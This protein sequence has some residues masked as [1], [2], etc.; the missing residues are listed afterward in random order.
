M[1]QVN[2]PGSPLVAAIVAS[3]AQVISSVERFIDVSL[4]ESDEY[5]VLAHGYQFIVHPQVLS[6]KYS[7]SAAFIASRW[8]IQPGMTVLDVGTGSGILAVLAAAAGA[9]HVTAVDVNQHAVRI[10]ERNA[11]LNGFENEISVGW[12][13]VFHSIEE[14]QQFDRIVVNAPYWNRCADP[15]LPLTLGLFD[16]DY[17]FA[18]RVISHASG[19]LKQCGKLFF[20]ISL[21]DDISPILNCIADSDL[22]VDKV[23]SEHFG[24]TRIM[25]SFSRKRGV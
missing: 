21:Q 6:P 18:R 7:H 4:S 1:P 13:D 15:S 8:D 16:N 22:T 2:S 24:H 5:I 19:Y 12:S 11:A 20:A 25:F 17:V 3:Q 10:A 9:E 23:D 14:V